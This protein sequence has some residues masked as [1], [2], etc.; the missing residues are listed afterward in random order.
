MTEV[1]RDV[2]S[3]RDLTRDS[4]VSLPA[5]PVVLAKVVLVFIATAFCRKWLLLWLLLPRLM[6][7]R[8]ITII[9]TGKIATR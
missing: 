3:M 9:I 8:E 1:I 4:A 7:K 6:K 2:G 5:L